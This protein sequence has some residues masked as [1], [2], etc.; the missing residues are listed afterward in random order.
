[1]SHY[2]NRSR[3]DR[4]FQAGDRVLLHTK[5]LQT[6][7]P[8]HK[9]ANPLAGPFTINRP[10]GHQAYRLDLPTM[11]KIHP[12]FHVSMLEEA[13]PDS[14]PSAHTPQAHTL[15]DDWEEFEVEAI[16]DSRHH[17]WVLQYQVKWVGY[18]EPTWETDTNLTGATNLVQAFHWDHPTKP[19][20]LN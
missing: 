13:T 19:A 12:V 5:H 8:S 17:Q 6:D 9:M 3:I 4:S 20:Q 14:R 1:M 16:L 10:V 11:W 2:Y 7:N 18:P 15:E